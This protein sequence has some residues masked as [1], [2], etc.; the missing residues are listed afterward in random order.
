MISSISFNLHENIYRE[1][2]EKISLII[3]IFFFLI[4]PN[5]T[6]LNTLKTVQNIH[7]SL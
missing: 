7:K 4:Q 3:I 1:L 6:E 2:F 5:C